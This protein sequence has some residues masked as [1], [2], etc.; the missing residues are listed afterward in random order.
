MSNKFY[1]GKTHNI[2]TRLNDHIFLSKG[3][4]WTTIY[5]P[6]S[7]SE[8]IPNCD[9]FDEDKYTLK[10]MKDY[11][12]DNVRGGSFSEIEL[13]EETKR[14]IAK[15]ISGATNCCFQCGS[16]DHFVKDCPKNIN[17]PKKVYKCYI[18]DSTDHFANNCPKKNASKPNSSGEKLF[19]PSNTSHFYNKY[20]ARPTNVPIDTPINTPTNEHINGI[21]DTTTSTNQQNITGPTIE[22]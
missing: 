22:I 4:D 7:I 14:F 13:S 19:P 21:V 8:I 10:Y 5:K 18:C 17:A 11:G 1:V 15:M 2:A 20:Q 3:S 9:A 12:I 16:K 6:T